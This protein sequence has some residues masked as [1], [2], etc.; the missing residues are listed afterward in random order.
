MDV[1]RRQV[2]S[3]GAVLPRGQPEVRARVEAA[4]EDVRRRPERRVRLVPGDPR[5]GAPCAGEVDRRRLRLRRRVD[6]ERCGEALGHPGAVL[7]RAHEDLLAVPALLLERRPRDL[8]LASRE[9]TAGHVGDASVLVRVDRIGDIVV[10]LRAVGRKRQEG[11]P[12]CRAGKQHAHGRK[13]GDRQPKT[14]RARGHFGRLRLH[15]TF[16]LF[17]FVCGSAGAGFDAVPIWSAE[18]DGRR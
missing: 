18:V 14:A 10:H 11:R 7:E 2:A 1:E 6:V 13:T 3:A 5:H 12:C 8:D 17:C 15:E 9:R 16:P 4:R